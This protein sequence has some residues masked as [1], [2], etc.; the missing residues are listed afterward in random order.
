MKDYS[1]Y[2]PNNHFY[3]GSED[4][5]GIVIDGQNFIAKF[6]KNT[7]IGLID[8][9]YSEFLGSHIF[10]ALGI[11]TQETRLGLYKGKE[12]VLMR[13]FTSK[14]EQFVPFNDVGDST[15]DED[16]DHFHYS[17][18]D[19]M[20]M[21]EANRKL[22]E[23]KETIS[24]FWDMYLVDALIGNFDRHG[25]NWGFLKKDDH[26]R[27]APVFDNGSSFFPRLNNDD[28]LKEVLS[29]EKEMSKR[30]FT[31]PTSQIRLG[32]R[33]SSYFEVISS[34]KFPE[35]NKAI[36][37]IVPKVHLQDLNAFIDSIP[38][39]SNTRKD[40]YKTILKMRFYGLLRGPYKELCR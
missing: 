24:F 28:S 6:Q 35:C 7:E 10:S 15:L 9:H 2:K 3:S 34:L 26:Y 36:L 8:N 16:K 14:N 27:V 17:Y 1:N 21:L 19:I 5:I 20:T 39:W 23:V 11:N 30:I 18:D 40:F 32:N 22:I 31:F 4:K 25:G 37:R 29:N 13:D 33:K 12:C 38:D